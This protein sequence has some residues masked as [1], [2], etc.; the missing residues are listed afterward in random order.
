MLKYKQNFI[1]NFANK[2]DILLKKGEKNHMLV[3]DGHS[4][5]GIDIFHGETNIEGYIEF[6]LRSGINAG[7]ITTVPSPCDILENIDSRRTWWLYNNK[8]I[9]HHGI[10]NPFLELNYQLNKLLKEKTN[11]KLQLFCIPMFHPIMDDID[12]FERMIEEIEPVALKLHGIGSGI[13]AN[14]ISKEF[15]KIIKKHELPLIVHTDCDLGNNFDQSMIWIRNINNAKS[16][17]EFFIQNEIYGTLNHGANLDIEA[18]ALINKTPFVK[19]ALGPAEISCLDSN[20]TYIDCK[21]NYKIYLQILRDYLDVSKIIYDADYNW[22]IPTDYKSVDRIK[23]VFN[24]YETDM[25]LSNNILSHYKK[26]K[27]RMR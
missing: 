4:H 5:F 24:Q 2:L 27:I 25:I 10:K 8:I 16:W 20:R 26:L 14:D 7:L 17:A 19:V 3:I 13:C 21:R 9:T 22:N 15:I 6:A 12:L 23:E 1:F 18:F 11:K